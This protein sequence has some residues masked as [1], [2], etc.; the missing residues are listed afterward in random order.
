MTGLLVRL[1]DKSLR[2]HIAA[3]E[4]QHDALAVPACVGPKVYNRCT[5]KKAGGGRSDKLRILQ[6]DHDAV[7]IGEGGDVVARDATEIENNPGPPDSSTDPDVGHPF[8]G[9]STQ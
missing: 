2:P 9:L 1:Q 6:F 4:V 5:D 3:I 7:R 8:G